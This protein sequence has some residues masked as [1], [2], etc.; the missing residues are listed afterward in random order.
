MEKKPKSVIY[1]TKFKQDIIDVYKYGLE[2]FGKTHAEEYQSEIYRLVSCLDVFYD[3]HINQITGH[4]EELQPGGGEL[5]HNVAAT[6]VPIRAE[7]GDHL[8]LERVEAF[9][10]DVRGLLEFGHHVGE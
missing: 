8:G 7:P 1:S 9:R 4:G 2:T 6:L 3:H 5:A 10:C